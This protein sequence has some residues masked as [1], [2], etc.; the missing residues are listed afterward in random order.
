MRLSLFKIGQVELR[1]SQ[2]EFREPQAQCLNIRKSLP[3]QM[4]ISWLTDTT[5]LM[6]V[7]DAPTHID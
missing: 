7:A 2:C 3:S 1:L 5:V 4:N 6:L